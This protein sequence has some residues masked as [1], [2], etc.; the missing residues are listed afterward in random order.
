VAWLLSALLY[1]HVLAAV[2]WFG[3]SLTLH[4]VF[5]PILNRLPFEAQLPWM[6]ALS[7]RYGPVIG[8]VG[9]ATVLFGVLRGIFSGVLGVLNTPYGITWLASI[10]LVI[11][12]IFVGAGLVGPTA[13]KMAATVQRDEFARLGSLVRRYGRFEL[14]GF[15]VMLALMV[16]LHAGY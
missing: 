4:L 16:A 14:A 8:P 6:Q 5:F 3:S 1:L 13:T 2:F 9:G 7:T 12:V 11:P 15:S 10:A